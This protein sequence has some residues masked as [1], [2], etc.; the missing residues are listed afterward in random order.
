MDTE[1][2]AAYGEMVMLA[3]QCDELLSQRKNQKAGID[4]ALAA[5]LAAGDDEN[6]AIMTTYKDAVIQLVIQL[7]TTEKKYEA[8]AK[9]LQALLL[10][11][12]I[13]PDDLMRAPEEVVEHIRRFNRDAAEEL[14]P[15]N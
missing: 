15:R 2:R 4:A 7:A 8:V 1:Q 12:D 11:S 5:L 10:A 3:R 6:F 13:G 14:A 9:Q